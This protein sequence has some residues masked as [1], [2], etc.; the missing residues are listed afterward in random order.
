MSF[1]LGGAFDEDL[2]LATPE[3]RSLA[4]LRGWVDRVRPR[5]RETI[6]APRR[7]FRLGAELFLTVG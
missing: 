2:R 4:T 6:G 7:R 1:L 3:L 5:R